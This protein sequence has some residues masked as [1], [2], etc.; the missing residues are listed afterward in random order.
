MRHRDQSEHILQSIHGLC[1]DLQV[2]FE[3]GTCAGR[4][5]D[6]LKPQLTELVAG[7]PRKMALLKEGRKGDRIGPRKL[8][9]LLY[10][11][12]NK[13]VYHGEHDQRMLRE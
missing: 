6:L 2:R 13:S 11:N 3:E 4:L 9:D 5:Y 7:N 12:K 10:M 1:G 8:A